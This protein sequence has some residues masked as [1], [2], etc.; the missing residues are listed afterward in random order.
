[1]DGNRTPLCISLNFNVLLCTKKNEVQHMKPMKNVG[2]LMM[3]VHAYKGSGHL[4][5]RGNNG[6]WESL[7]CRSSV[8]PPS[9]CVAQQR[10]HYSGE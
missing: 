10:K 9:F 1:M 5:Y 6:F 7:A 3:R 4:G 2:G 8:L